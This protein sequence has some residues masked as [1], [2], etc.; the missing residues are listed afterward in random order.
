MAYFKFQHPFNC[1]LAGPS[2]SGKT[3]LITK[4]LTNTSQII[5]EEIEEVIWHYAIF[6]DTLFHSL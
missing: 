2:Q 1:I 3:T 6:Q 4:I 5:D